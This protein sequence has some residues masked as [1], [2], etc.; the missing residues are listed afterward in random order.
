QYSS[1]AA[2]LPPSYV[3]GVRNGAP[4]ADPFFA[5]P[6]REQFPTFVAGV[7]LAGSVFDRNIRTTYVQQYNLTVQYEA[8][9]NLLLEVGYVGTRGINLFRQVA[10][11]QARLASP[12]NPIINEV[13]GTT[14]TMNTP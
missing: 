5:L 10:I 12:Q 2:T 1:L 8:V 13:T 7:P 4:L 14:I 3:I 9:K 11:D 6:L